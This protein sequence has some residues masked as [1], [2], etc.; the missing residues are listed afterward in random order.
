[1]GEHEILN[2]VSDSSKAKK[3]RERDV[4]VEMKRKTVLLVIQANISTKA[5]V[6]VMSQQFRYGTS[7]A[8]K[9][10]ARFSENNVKDVTA[11]HMPQ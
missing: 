11:D 10:R 5:G 9:L 6:G 3:R 1:M 2:E 4:I 7:F 8:V